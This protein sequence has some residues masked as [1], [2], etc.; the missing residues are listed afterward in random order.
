MRK[1]KSD[2]KSCRDV[3][4][5]FLVTLA[6]YAGIFEFP[7]IRPTVRVPNR[8]V[9]FSKAIGCKDFDQ[10]VHF[11][12]FDHLFERVWRNPRRYLPILMRFNG[13]ILPDF[14]VYRDMPLVM[15]LWNIY[16]SR[17]IGFWLQANGVE[18]IANVRWGDR[19]TYR[20][21]CD[22]VPKSCTIAVGTVGAVQ[23]AEDRRFF[24]EGLA[25]VVRHLAPNVIVVYGSAPEEIFG[26]YREAGIEIVQFDSE[27]S[28]VHG[29]VA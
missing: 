16:R 1:F 4:N 14:S 27:N 9:L 25:I 20:I 24:E 19:R 11:Y 5:A 2:M 13:V 8:L 10:W 21:C 18:V 26:K 6:N 29:E 3:F 22:G 15:Q 12:E 17:A 28:R 7:V 23:S